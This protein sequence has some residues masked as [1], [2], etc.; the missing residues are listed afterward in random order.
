MD[1]YINLPKAKIRTIKPTN[2]NMANQRK[3]QRLWTKYRK[4]FSSRVIIER[5]GNQNSLLFAFEFLLLEF[6]LLKACSGENRE[7]EVNLPN[8]GE[9]QHFNELR[10]GDQEQTKSKNTSSFSGKTGVI[11][12]EL[13]RAEKLC[14][15]I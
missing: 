9:R 1:P 7:R 8:F 2:F 5:T 14:A 15:A 10:P 11:R 12:F 4:K 3:F 13:D 6:K